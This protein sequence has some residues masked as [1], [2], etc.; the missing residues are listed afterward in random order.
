MTW[1]TVLKNTRSYVGDSFAMAHINASIENAS[2]ENASI[3]N[4]SIENASI[5]NAC[6]CIVFVV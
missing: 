2:I 4:A 5:E 6:H 3:E 1:K